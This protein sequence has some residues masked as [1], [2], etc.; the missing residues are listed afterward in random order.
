MGISTKPVRIG[1]RHGW[2]RLG[3]VIRIERPMNR[4]RPPRTSCVGYQ[5]HFVCDTREV[6][7]SACRV[8]PVGCNRLRT[9]SR[10]CLLTF[11]LCQVLILAACSTPVTPDP[12][13]TSPPEVV[14]DVHVEGEFTPVKTQ[15]V[16]RTDI[17]RGATITFLGL[18][19]DPESG[20]RSAAIRGEIV[21]SCISRSDPDIGRRR[22][23]TILVRKPEQP[24]AQPPGQFP[25]QLLVQLNVPYAY[26]GCSSD[27]RPENVSG[28]LHLDGENGTGRNAETAIYSFRFANP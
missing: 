20:V 8:D 12:T 4:R 13:D 26:T 2:D 14:L 18:A 23:A 3:R 9:R 27:F 25:D 19:R 16:T 11:A 5:A 7:S 15:P 10:N 17:P 28:V 1:N 6:T 22:V 24:P 21:T